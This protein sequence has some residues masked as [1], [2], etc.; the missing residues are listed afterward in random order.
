MEVPYHKRYN[1]LRRRDEVEVGRL[2]PRD[3]S[4][5]LGGGFSARA[6]RLQ[7]L[8]KSVRRTASSLKLKAGRRMKRG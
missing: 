6:S 7:R 1:R 3:E 2:T 4:R 8:S 5:R